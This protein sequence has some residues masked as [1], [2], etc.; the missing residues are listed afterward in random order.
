MNELLAVTTPKGNHLTDKT[1][2]VFRGNYRRPPPHTHTHLNLTVKTWIRTAYNFLLLHVVL[3]GTNWSF[4]IN[5]CDNVWSTS[6]VPVFEPF[7]V[8]AIGVT[9]R[10]TIRVTLNQGDSDSA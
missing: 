2:H 7:A 5:K 10:V 6:A 4:V 1:S 3:S 8:M 9:I